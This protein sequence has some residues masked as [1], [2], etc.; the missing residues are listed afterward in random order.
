MLWEFLY[1]TI[2]SVRKQWMDRQ[3]KTCDLCTRQLGE[4]LSERHKPELTDLY[5][6]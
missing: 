1:T 4:S 6:S 3:L 2:R 5:L